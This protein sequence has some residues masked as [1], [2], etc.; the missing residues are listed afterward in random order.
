M[1]ITRNYGYLP[2]HLS[3]PLVFIW[4]GFARFLV[5]CRYLFLPLSFLVVVLSVLLQFTVSDNHF[6]IF[7]FF[8]AFLIKSSKRDV[9]MMC[10]LLECFFFNYLQGN[11][12]NYTSVYKTVFFTVILSRITFDHDLVDLYRISAST[13]KT[14]T[15][16]L[17]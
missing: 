12:P 6:G 7:K 15:F 2:E 14:D 10:N 1:W 3:S 17:P 9:V 5:F 16:L 8:S 11:F 13:I 4:V